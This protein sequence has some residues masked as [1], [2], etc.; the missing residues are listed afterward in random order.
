MSP[1]QAAGRPVDA[2]ADVFS[3]GVT[4]Y[5]MLTGRQAFSGDSDV[6]VLYQIIHETPRPLS[7]INPDAPSD[8]QAV[9]ERCTAK[10]PAE[11]YGSGRELCRDIKRARISLDI[12]R[13]RTLHTLFSIS[14]EMTSILE[15]EPLLDR[16]STLIKSLIDYEVLGIY[17]ADF[18]KNRLY[19]LGGAGYDADRAKQTEY[20]AD[21]GLCGRAIRT[22][23]P[24]RVGDVT[25]D[26]DYYPPQ[27]EPFQSNLVIPLLYKDKVIGCVNMES[28]RP[29]FF[30]AEHQT[31]MSTLAGVIAVAVENARL[32]NEMREHGKA[33]ELLHE[34]GRE[35]ASILDPD[36]LL[37]KVGEL[38]KKVIDHDLFA[39]FLLDEA[40]ECFTWRKATGYDPEFVKERELRLGEG[41][42]SR[43]VQ[44]REP[45]MVDDVTGDPDYVAPRTVN[46]RAPK[47]EIA[48]PLVAQDKVHG[49]MVLESAEVGR[50]TPGHARLLSVLASQVAVA[51]ENAHLYREIQDRARIREEEAERIRRRFESYVTP[52]IAE[53][54][55]RNPKG[56][57]LAGERRPV[58]VLVA[59]IRGFT[60]LAESLP[61]ESAVEFLQEFFS[62]MTQVVFKYEGTVDKFLGDAIMAF[63]GAPVAHDPRFGPSDAQ[64]AVY[65]AIDMRDAFA[66]LRDKWWGR[67]SEFGTL[68]LS[69]GVNTGTGLM[70]NMGSDRRVEYT[71]LG[72][73]VNLAF[74]LCRE[75][76][77]GEIRIGARTRT[78]IRDDIQSEPAASAAAPEAPE[79]HVVKGLKYLS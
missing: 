40:S 1:E 57:L 10:D 53:Q 68:G 41:L 9:V 60:P 11:R 32:F 2:R 33:M 16:V 64:R 66:R 44:S 55:F 37:D 29:H 36:Y 5:E 15:L 76:A 50:F 62:V 14:R 23:E 54:V 24:V 77:P 72:S 51:M 56:K 75:A 38:T 7:E 3:F 34:I 43:A 65:A 63:Y 47:S 46:G 42:I 79:S 20:L 73:G 49:V 18:A 8:L 26:P 31:V 22:G 19:W 48:V 71:A 61:P 28:R 74:T 30:T 45:V 21:K 13:A 69:I 58:T 12:Q 35:V 17:R 52:H 67:H 78:L 4:L 39:I 59:D 27:G 6:D 70:G 25:A